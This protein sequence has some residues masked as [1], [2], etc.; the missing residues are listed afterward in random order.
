MKK[1]L[2]LLALAV[3]S[4]GT[5]VAAETPVYVGATAGY[6]HASNLGVK[7]ADH[8]GASGAVFAGYQLSPKAAVELGY[9]R[10][11][12]IGDFGVKAKP[13]MVTLQGVGKTSVL[14]AKTSVFAKGGVAFTRV[15]G[16]V[17]ESHLAPVVGFGA[18]YALNKNVS[19]QAEVQYV[20]DF[21][22][23]DARAFN[24]SVGLKYHF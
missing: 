8:D 24:T 12:D 9:T 2:T 22:G 17:R 14:N 1:T 15:R 13:E 6:S 16:D 10:L 20:H 21:A 11:S 18:E 19:A 7:L 3:A 4:M 5:A 23:T